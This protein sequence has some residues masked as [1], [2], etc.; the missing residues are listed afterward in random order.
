M[1]VANFCGLAAGITPGEHSLRD[2]LVGKFRLSDF[3]AFSPPLN[4]ASRG[5]DAEDPNE[6]WKVVLKGLR[7]R[8]RAR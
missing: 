8:T 7:F 4:A 6:A 1:T 2:D 3:D 5:D